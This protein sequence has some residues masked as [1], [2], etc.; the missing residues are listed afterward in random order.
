MQIHLGGYE[1]R[2]PL[3]YRL[4]LQLYRIDLFFVSD[5]PVL[6]SA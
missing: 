1:T 2:Q 5:T 3:F 6:T 4:T